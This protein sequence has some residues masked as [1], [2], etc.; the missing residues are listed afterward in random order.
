MSLPVSRSLVSPSSLPV[1]L[2]C[3]SVSS[4]CIANFP[5]HLLTYSPLIYLISIFSRAFVY[6]NLIG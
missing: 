6:T 3:L 1:A 4:P 5:F 2:T